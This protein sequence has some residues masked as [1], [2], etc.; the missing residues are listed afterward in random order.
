M[1]AHWFQHN[2]LY[3]NY[4]NTLIYNPVLKASS[5]EKIKKN[6]DVLETVQNIEF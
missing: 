1:Y 3:V 6:A 2:A 4:Q 5:L